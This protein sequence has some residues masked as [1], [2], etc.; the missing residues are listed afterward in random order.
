MIEEQIKLRDNAIAQANLLKEYKQLFVHHPSHRIN[1]N[2]NNNKS[3]HNK[4]GSTGGG[5]LSIFVSLLTEPLSRTGMMRS[6]DD[7]LTVELILHLFRNLLCAGE[8]LLKDHD[9]TRE[10]AKL[11]Q[12][13][14]SLFEQELV[15]DVLV[16]IGQEMESR[17]NAQYN[18]LIMEI[19]HHL[20]KSQVRIVCFGVTLCFCLLFSQFV[21]HYFLLLFL[22]C[23]II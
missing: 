19:M 16:M 21:T 12:E 14:I 8:P 4:Q 10:S 9:N 15:L 22:Y 6:D 18:L 11:H 7:H 20:L 5:L 3:K 2:T 23:T 1:N 17:E 13:L